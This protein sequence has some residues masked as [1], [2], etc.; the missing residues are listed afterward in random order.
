MVEDKVFKVII[1]GSR[2]IDINDENYSQWEKH[3]VSI[4]MNA[5]PFDCK[6][7]EIVSGTAKGADKFG[8]EV[9][10][11]QC[12]AL[13]SFPAKWNEFREGDPVKENSRGKYNPLAGHRR[14]ED[15]GDYADFLIAIWDGKSKGTKHMID[16]MVK[17]KKPFMIIMSQS[18]PLWK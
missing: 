10:E 13:K 11:N 8:E 6:L 16:Y 18:K 2:D 17:L 1:A 5:I 9:A 3:V 4:I 15:M 7:I 14:N 12:F